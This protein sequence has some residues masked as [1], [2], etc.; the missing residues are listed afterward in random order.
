MTK[1]AARKVIC[2]NFIQ[3]SKV[4]L[5]EGIFSGKFCFVNHLLTKK[6]SL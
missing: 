6:L 5:F 3:T 2:K 1:K 4:T